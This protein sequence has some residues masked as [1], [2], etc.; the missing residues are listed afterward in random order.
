MKFS[1]TILSI[2][3]MAVL[4][5]GTACRK[6]KNTPLTSPVSFTSTTY[7]GLGPYNEFGTPDNMGTKDVVSGNLFAFKDNTLPETKDLRTSNPN[8]LSASGNA[9]LKV[10]SKS[11]VAIV[12]VSQGTGFA[13]TIAFYSYPTANPP[14]TAKDIKQ[15]TYIFPNAGMGTKLTMGDKVNIGTFEAGTSIGFVLLKNAWNP[16]TKTINKDAVHFCSNDVLNPE[17]DA[18]LKKHAVLFP[19][20]AENKI[21]IGF[22]DIDRTEAECDHDFNDVVVYAAVTAAP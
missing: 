19:Y 2:A 20:T 1:T 7:V 13:N 10:T 5:T 4:V 6:S 18:S 8:L 11:N 22:E 9:D 15:I 21:L 3:S 16:A 12:F 17:A 14:A